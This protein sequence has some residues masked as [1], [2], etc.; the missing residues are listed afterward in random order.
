MGG[1]LKTGLLSNPSLLTKGDEDFFDESRM[2]IILRASE[3]SFEPVEEEFLEPV[4]AGEPGAMQTINIDFGGGITVACS[5]T[6]A[7]LASMNVRRGDRASSWTRTVTIS[8]PD[9]AEPSPDAGS[10]A[11]GRKTTGSINGKIIP[12]V[13]TGGKGSATTTGA[14]ASLGG[15][16]CTASVH[17]KPGQAGGV[18]GTNGSRTAPDASGPTKNHGIGG[19]GTSPGSG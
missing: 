5:I 4:E 14:A 3:E 19:G 17:P 9:G 15:P 10:V 8:L 6:S 2:G 12:Q 18:N 13:A 7:A 1:F 11:A 16:V